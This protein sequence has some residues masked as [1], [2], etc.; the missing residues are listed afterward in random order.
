MCVRDSTKWEQLFEKNKSWHCI[1]KGTV[2]E[3][4]QTEAQSELQKNVLGKQY[5]DDGDFGIEY[6]KVDWCLNKEMHDHVMW[7]DPVLHLHWST[8]ILHAKKRRIRNC[9]FRQGI[10]FI[11]YLQ[12]PIRRMKATLLWILLWICSTLTST[13]LFTKGFFADRKVQWIQ[14]ANP[15]INMMMSNKS[16]RLV[17]RLMYIDVYVWWRR[18]QVLMRNV[19]TSQQER[20]VAYNG[21]D[22]WWKSNMIHSWCVWEMNQIGTCLLQI[23]LNLPYQL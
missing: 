6:L 15:M 2:N 12:G 19:W 5:T 13:F 10:T 22:L 4:P 20:V 23:E 1:R 7:H 14:L 8:N 17:L 3:E 16:Q 11:I 21:T 9:Y 18:G